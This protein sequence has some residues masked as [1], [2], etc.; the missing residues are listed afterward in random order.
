MPRP[1]PT[2]HRRQTRARQFAAEDVVR[3]DQR[4]RARIDFDRRYEVDDGRDPEVRQRPVLTQAQLP[5]AIAVASMLYAQGKSDDARKVLR[6]ILALDPHDAV[7]L[8]L[9]KRVAHTAADAVKKADAMAHNMEAAGEAARLRDEARMGEMA[10]AN[11]ENDAPD[12]VPMRTGKKVF[13]ERAPRTLPPW[14]DENDASEDTGTSKSSFTSKTLDDALSMARTALDP[15]LFAKP[16]AARGETMFHDKE[17]EDDVRKGK[18][19]GVVAPKVT[20]AELDAHL[21]AKLAREAAQKKA[22]WELEVSEAQ[23][24]LANMRAEED[25]EKDARRAKVIAMRRGL[26]E[27]A[28]RARARHAET[29]AHRVEESV[30]ALSG[31]DGGGGEVSRTGKKLLRPRKREPAPWGDRK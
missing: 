4:D 7:A 25:A 2:P 1:D 16:D 11:D 9:L 15:D 31:N 5:A 21:E 18:K 20:T 24:A 27:G 12:A 29:H 17:T 28:A 14:L 8:E 13:P 30:E 23:R 3:K 19:R 10:R 6:Q 26:D 22:D